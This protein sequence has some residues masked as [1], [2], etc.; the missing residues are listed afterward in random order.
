MQSLMFKA[1]PGAGPFDILIGSQAIP[2]SAIGSGPNY[3][4]YAANISAWAG[5]SEELSFSALNDGG[6]NNWVLD[7]IT[8]S[9][10]AVP[11]PSTL[12]LLVMGGMALAARRWRAKG[13]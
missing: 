5:R 8:F 12:A 7:D 3:T 4:L 11:E 6:V 2:F 13:S 1:Q 10:N 9:P